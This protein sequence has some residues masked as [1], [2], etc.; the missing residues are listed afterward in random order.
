MRQCQ[1]F[2]AVFS[3]HIYC[4]L[5][6]TISTAPSIRPKYQLHFTTPV[7]Q[8]ELLKMFLQKIL[9]LP[10]FV[11]MRGAGGNVCVCNF[12][13]ENLVLLLAEKLGSHLTSQIIARG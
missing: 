2:A 9:L 4:H 5:L 10:K 11:H 3:E 8:R 12:S 6:D 13:R 1:C 7:L